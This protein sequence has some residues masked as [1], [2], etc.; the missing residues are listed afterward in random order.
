MDFGTKH[1]SSH[2]L[3][4]AFIQILNFL[5]W[6]NSFD[7]ICVICQLTCEPTED[8]DCFLFLPMC[9]TNFNILL[10]SLYN[11]VPIRQT[12]CNYLLIFHASKTLLWTR[13]KWEWPSHILSFF[14]LRLEEVT[15]CVCADW[16][17]I[18]F[19]RI[20]F[21]PWQLYDR[22]S[23]VADAEFPPFLFP[24]Q[25]LNLP[26]TAAFSAKKRQEISWGHSISITAG[27][28]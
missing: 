19:F 27:S 2:V 22:L 23:V 4:C 10:W 1:C 28:G 3:F 15:A 20:S 17:Q 26:I 13:S 9:W 14:H 12:T 6:F 18:E 5:L 11:S 24:C 25:N 8:T 7:S 21:K 16:S